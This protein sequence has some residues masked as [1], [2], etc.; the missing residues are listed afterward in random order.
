MRTETQQL[1]TDWLEENVGILFKV[2]RGFLEDQAG[3]DVAS[4]S[5]S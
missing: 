3:Q 1:E 5:M 4:N 2:C